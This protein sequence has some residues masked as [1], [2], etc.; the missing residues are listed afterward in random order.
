MN[1]PLRIGVLGLGM[2]GR[3]HVAATRK[4]AMVALVAVADA[5]AEARAQFEGP[6]GCQVTEGIDALLA[7]EPDALV[8]ALPHALLAN[9]AVRAA[10]A[11]RHVLVEK[12]MAN[13]VATASAVVAAAKAANVRLMVNYN[14]RFREEYVVAKRWLQ[15]GRIG[16]PR[17]FVDQWFATAGPL[18]AWVWQPDVAGGGLMTYSG[19]HMVDRLLWL[20]ERSVQSVTASTDTFHAASPLEDTCIVTLRFDD[21]SLGSLVQ[22]KSAV[23]HR[24]ARWESTIQ[25]TEGAIRVTS[26]EGA[27]VSGAAGDESYRPKSD[28]N[29]ARFQRA[30]EEFAAAVRERRP[31]QPDAESGL[32]TLAC[33]EAIYRAAKAGG[34]HVVPGIGG[35]VESEIS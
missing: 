21:G 14:H 1:E 9:A 10:S 11:G 34:A 29:V 4:T 15:E 12:P 13:D 18:P 27:E 35:R 24:L 6:Q 33:L 7:C 22:H 3:Q 16:R 5:S 19:A 28:G 23:P 26:N 20:S 25:G 17:L 31:P 32:R 2:A 30:L 8:I